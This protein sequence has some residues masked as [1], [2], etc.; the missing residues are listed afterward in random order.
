MFEIRGLTKQYRGSTVC[1]VDNLNLILN[2]GE[3]VG[4][5]GANGAGKTTAIKCA[6]G[7]LPFAEG[8]IIIDGI[9]IVK[10]PVEAKKR[11]GYVADNYAV[12]DKLTGRQYINFLSDV[13]D[14]GLDDRTARLD[15]FAKRF[16]LT[17][18]LDNPIK[19]YSHGM[20]QKISI[21]GALIHN[22]KVWILDEPLTGLDPQ[23]AHELKMLMREHCEKGNVVF[24]S[25]H[26]L[27][28]VEKLCDRVA[29]VK[30]GKLVAV[31][32]IDEMKERKNDISLEDFFLEIVGKD[33]DNEL[34]LNEGETV[35]DNSDISID[36]TCD[37]NEKDLSTAT[38]YIDEAEDK[39]VE[40]S[41]DNA[42][43]SSD[44][45]SM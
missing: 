42:D 45:L 19:S 41:S 38:I 33:S 17:D 18:K 43:N 24:F 15:N 14:V 20:K 11:I 39:S 13:Y 27:E 5:L 16:D 34:Q 2:A 21:I 32:D 26:I 44:E 4:F 10:D 30:G 23:S 29:I 25:S 7:V 35:N 37:N 40:I 1:A 8:D 28:V 31:F 22:P 36:A 6:T 3:V 9:S 12:Y